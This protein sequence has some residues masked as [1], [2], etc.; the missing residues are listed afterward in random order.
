MESLLNL[1]R[2]QPM[3][4]TVI[5]LISLSVACLKKYSEQATA[6]AR[7]NFRKDDRTK[8]NKYRAVRLLYIFSKIYEKFLH[9]NLTNYMNSFR[10]CLPQI[11]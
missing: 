8:I 6:T 3:L 1:L 5:Y 11:L 2:C 4:L 9:K 7:P 10:F